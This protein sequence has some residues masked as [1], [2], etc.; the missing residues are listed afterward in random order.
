L[1]CEGDPFFYG[2]S[3]YLFDRLRDNYAHEIVPGVC[4]MSGCWAAAGTPIVHGD[5]VLTILPGTLDG[6]S[7]TAHLRACDGAV[8]MKVGRN[9]EKIRSALASAGLAER[10]I[11]V[12]RGTMAGQ[13]VLPLADVIENDA[14]Y[15]SLVLIPGRQRKR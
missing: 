5:D 6:D 8:I 2:S 11:Y 1:L 4:A 9:L 13:R 3:M 14:P 10:A 12:E 15:F 7:L